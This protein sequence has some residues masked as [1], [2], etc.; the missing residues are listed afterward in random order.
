MLQLKH[1]ALCG[2]E[3]GE[4]EEEADMEE[5]QEVVVLADQVE[6]NGIIYTSQLVSFKRL[7][8]MLPHPQ[9]KML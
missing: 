7:R 4:V 1:S 5:I 3:G 8:K 9:E 2:G 6:V